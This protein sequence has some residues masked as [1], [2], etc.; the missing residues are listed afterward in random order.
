MRNCLC[1]ADNNDCI[2]AEKA[3][4]AVSFADRIQGMIG[5]SFAKVP[6]DAMIFEKCNAVHCCW[7]S[8][9]IDVIFVNDNWEVV[10]L[11]SDLKPWRFASG[12]RISR[13]AIELPAGKIRCCGLKTGDRLI[14]KDLTGERI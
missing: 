14:W 5:R 4:F 3:R 12:G 10:R 13:T 6:F 9:A 1:K 8:E 11:Y 2:I 7:M